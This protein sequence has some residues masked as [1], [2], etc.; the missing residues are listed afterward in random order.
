MT[1]LPKTFARDLVRAYQYLYY[2]NAMSLIS[3]PEYDRLQKD[4]EAETG[5]VIPVGSD[6]I[7][8]YTKAEQT[9][10]VYLRASYLR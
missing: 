6:R 1:H 5:D 8:D 4:Y 9:L 3:D 10:A 7:L 2:V